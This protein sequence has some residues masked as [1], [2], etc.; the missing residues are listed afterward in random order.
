MPNLYILCGPSGCGKTTWCNVFM[1]ENDVRYVSRDEIRFSMLKDDED[2]FA[3]EVDVFKKFTGTLA[4]TLVDGFDV[5]ADATHLNA[6]SRQ[7]LTQAIDMRITDYNIIYVVFNTTCTQCII[8]NHQRE[9]RARVPDNVIT[10]MFRTYS[11]PT[12]DED[13]R[14]TNIIEV[15]EEKEDFSYLVLSYGKETRDE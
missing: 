13:F 11:K 6:R 14:A 7:R 3:H 15:G 2:Y 12:L 1:R 4:Q 8:N 5:I 9:G 10:G